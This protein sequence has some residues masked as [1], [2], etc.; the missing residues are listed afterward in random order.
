MYV[1]YKKK[2][3]SS[4]ATKYKNH[5]SLTLGEHLPHVSPYICR[6]KVRQ[7]W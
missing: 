7:V 4:H 3:K 2:K 6:Q 1:Y 5:A